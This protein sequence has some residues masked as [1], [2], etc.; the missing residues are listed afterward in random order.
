MD[1]IE[2]FIAQSNDAKS[3]EDVFT[4]FCRALERLGYDSVVYSLLTD[5]VSLNR[6]AGHGV[7]CNYP[8]DWMEYYNKQGYLPHDPVIHHAFTTSAPYTWK[9]LLDQKCVSA[10]QERILN[11]SKE[12]KLLDGAAVAIYGPKFEI[13][14]VGLA[15]TS[16][17]VD[18]D[19]NT[20][21]IIRALANQFHITYSE[22]DSNKNT[23]K[24]QYVVLTPREREILMWSAEGKSVSTIA[25]IL[26]VSD[27][28]VK[29]HLK[30]I[31]RKLDVSDRIQAVVKAIYMGLINPS[32]IRHF[33]TL[34][35]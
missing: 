14:G 6:K 31:Y 10:K 30:N 24:P 19:K 21:A 17:G 27:S 26:S 1:I 22:L 34:P 15:S 2:N 25:S 3:Q 32:N 13:A 5:H 4:H 11:E 20:L 28:S 33:H 9:Q 8:A 12:A 35:S 29:F 23:E 18:P 16:G 7:M